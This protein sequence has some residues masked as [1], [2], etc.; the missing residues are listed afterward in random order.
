MDSDKYVIVRALACYADAMKR[1]AEVAKLGGSETMMAK[2]MEG[3][4]EMAYS[5]R[6][7]ILGTIGGNFS[8]KGVKLK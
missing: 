2:I 8:E 4:A 6:E 1:G 3:E 5:A 7:R